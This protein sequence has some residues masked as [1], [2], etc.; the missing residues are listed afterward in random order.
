MIKGDIVLVLF[1]FTD[2]KENKYRPAVVL[3]ASSL[4]VTV[5]FVSSQLKWKEE[6][7]LEVN[8]TTSNGLKVISLVRVRKI[9]T[10]DNELVAGKLGALDA[11]EIEN[12]N[13]SL[14]KVFNL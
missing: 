14:V 11:N 9:M 6:H 4:D 10:I 8:P 12:L 5:C 3:T 13:H 2:L 7:D 1:P